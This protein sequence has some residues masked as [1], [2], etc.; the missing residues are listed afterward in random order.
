MDNIQGSIQAQTEHLEKP[1]IEK[2][3]LCCWIVMPISW[4]GDYTK[5]HWS[6][7]K[8]IIQNAIWEAWF[9]ARLVSDADDS[10]IIQ[11][12]IIQNLYEDPIVVV[13]VSGK[14]PN[15]MFELGL[16]LAFDKPT[17]IIK[18]DKTDYS[19][20]TAP[21]EHLCYP[22]DL[23]Y[24]T[25]IDFKT[26]LRD[27][28]IAT[29]KSAT[30][31]PAYTTFL[32]H[33]GTVKVATLGEKTV[34]RDDYILSVLEDIKEEARRTRVTVN[35]S[36]GRIRTYDQLVNSQLLY[37]WA[38]EE[39]GHCRACRVFVKKIWKIRKVHT[40][41][42]C[43][44]LAKRGVQ[45][46]LLA[47]GGWLEMPFKAFLPLIPT[48]GMNLILTNIYL[49]SYA[50]SSGNS[51]SGKAPDSES[52][53]GGSNP[54]FPTNVHFVVSILSENLEKNL[55]SRQ[56]IMLHGTIFWRF[57][58]NMVNPPGTY[59]RGFRIHWYDWMKKVGIIL[60]EPCLE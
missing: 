54:S 12:R 6:D 17:I 50:F 34:W 49:L 38:T 41:G 36:P 60:Y 39:L 32:K 7:V 21:I 43:W 42:L 19:F 16:R 27:K 52:G 24:Q 29:H 13:D 18:D 58:V 48:Y 3:I 31:D 9:N 8:N 20:D 1:E 35:G 25:I 51:P 53:I 28:I 55:F 10:W 4:S 37:H 45:M 56:K 15:V 44:G 11:K 30:N 47:S 23:R 22:R 57:G 5:E 59:T 46:I 2:E 14:N 40:I 33:F 26:K